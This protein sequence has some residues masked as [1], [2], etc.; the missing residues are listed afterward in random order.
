M[1]KG[2]GSIPDTPSNIH[3]K[4]YLFNWS[5]VTTIKEYFCTRDSGTPF[6]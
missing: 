1:T 5:L 3:K 4:R 6:A 2:L